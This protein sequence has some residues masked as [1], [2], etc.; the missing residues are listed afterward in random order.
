MCSV[1][2]NV[3]LPEE[4]ELIK[5]EGGVWKV[6]GKPIV[7]YI[8]GDGIGPEV[9]KPAIEIINE[10]VELCYGSSRRIV[11]VKLYA[12][13]E[14]EKKFGTRLPE[15]TIRYLEVIRVLFKGP[16]YTPAG[17]GWRS[18]NVYLRQYL[19]LYANIR[20]VRYIEG[21]PSPLR[22]P[23]GIDLVIFRENT[24]DLYVGIEWPWDSQEAK[25][26][27]ELLRRELGVELPDDAG[28]GI[29]PMSRFKTYRI[30]RAAIR[31]AIST[32]RRVITVVHKGNI[33]KYTEGA[34]RN[35]VYEVAL[36]E[37]RDYIVTEQEVLEK[38]GGVVPEGKILLNDRLMDNMLQQ[39]ILNPRQFSVIVCPNVN[40][41][42]LSDAAAALVGGV[43]VAPS[44]NIGD[45][46]A[47][48][49][50]VHGT[51][52]DI[53]GKGIANPTAAILS[54]CLMLEYMGWHEAAN[55]I[56]EALQVVIKSGKV[57]LDLAKQLG[58]NRYL[59]TEEFKREV[60]ETMKTL[61]K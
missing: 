56:R 5:I 6:P 36:S 58:L 30:A 33:M 27:R 55:L 12:G 15:E 13:D 54:G 47:L 53:A 26:L 4:G 45:T 10:A 7:A 46:A 31:Y 34:F 48:F 52:P 3:K 2:V 9:I 22:D 44:A 18:I 37:F 43:S 59:T 20:P 24:D 50:P 35:W 8:E 60:I 21:L 23:R 29:K 28:I 61:V 25:R 49:E 19:D 57:T 16:L 32:G 1:N 17:G 14:A 42:Y 51:A 39:I 11:W 38:Y 41:D 40:G